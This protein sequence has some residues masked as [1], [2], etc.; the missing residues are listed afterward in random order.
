MIGTTRSRVSFFMN[1]F[2]LDE[3]LLSRA[4]EC[5]CKV[6]RGSFVKQLNNQNNL[7]S[8]QLQGG[9]SVCDHSVFFANGKHDLREW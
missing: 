9:E 4:E 6:Q 2:A 3:A 8:A 5:G 1:R 7:W